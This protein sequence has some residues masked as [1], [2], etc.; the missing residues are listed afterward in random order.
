MVHPQTSEIPSGTTASSADN[1]NNVTVTAKNNQEVTYN[2]KVDDDDTF[3]ATNTP[4]GDLRQALYNSITRREEEHE[5]EE[6]KKKDKKSS[7]KY[8]R[9]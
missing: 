8:I 4:Y 6:E 5:K 1:P 7:C 9:K 2:V 3:S